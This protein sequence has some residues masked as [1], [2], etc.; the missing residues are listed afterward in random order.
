MFRASLF[1]VNQNWE[2]DLAVLHLVSGQ[3]SVHTADCYSLANKERW[4]IDECNSID[5]S[6]ICH[7]RDSQM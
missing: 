7:M 5:K 3:R 2:E 6:Q 4:A 1:I